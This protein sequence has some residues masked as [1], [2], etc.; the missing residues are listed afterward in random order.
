MSDLY[1]MIP[2]NIKHITTNDLL[3]DQLDSMLNQ[4]VNKKEFS[5]RRYIIE[6]LRSIQLELEWFFK[7]TINREVVDNH[8]YCGLRI[9]NTYILL[10]LNELS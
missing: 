9:K 6:P 7:K 2:I 8:V 5:N 1:L 10:I 3:M 4:L